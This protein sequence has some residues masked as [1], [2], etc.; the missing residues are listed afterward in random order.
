M[1][2]SETQGE[3]QVQVTADHDDSTSQVQHRLL[4]VDTRMAHIQAQVERLMAE[5]SATSSQFAVL[6]R[7]MT[8]PQPLQGL[9]ERLGELLEHGESHQEHLNLVVS[10]LEDLAGKEQLAEISSTITRL[11]RTQFKSN[12]LGETK[13]QH[14]ERSLSTL[15]ELLT[16][17]EEHHTQWQDRLEEQ[18]EAVRREARGE[19]AAELLPA[20]DSVDLALASGQ[21]LVVRQRQEVAAWEQQHARTARQPE[22]SPPATG[23]WRKIR[24]KFV[25][26]A[27]PVTSTPPRPPPLPEAVT[28]M[29]D[30][31]EAWLQGLTLMRERFLAVLANEGI[32]AMEALHAPFDPR[33]HVAVQAE[34]RDDVAPHTVVRVLRQGYRQQQRVLRYAEVVVARAADG[35]Q[36]I[37]IVPQEVQDE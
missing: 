14:I 5:V 23:M 6:L 31:M 10:K 19:L 11:G 17:R 33:L 15:Q 8:D 9:H 36:P 24:R 1:D 37:N 26:R 4:H 12:A 30:V 25:G 16:H 34:I 20:L 32:E 13:E 29:P 22:L 27:V 28:A 18:F 3:A 2:A 7:Q 35:Q 21:A